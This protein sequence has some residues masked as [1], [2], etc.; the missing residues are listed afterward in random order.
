MAVVDRHVVAADAREDARDARERL[1]CDR[2]R[3]RRHRGRARQGACHVIGRCVSV[4]AR[5]ARGRHVRD[6]VRRR[7]RARQDAR[8]ARERRA[9]V[10][11]KSADSL[12]EIRPAIC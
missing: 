6:H 10:V 2:A 11:E 9:R 8:H 4:V 5:D 12:F 1:A 3:Q 7:G